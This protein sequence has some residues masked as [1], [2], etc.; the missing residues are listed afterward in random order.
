VNGHTPVVVAFLKRAFRAVRIA[1][2]DERIPRPLRWFAALGL[3]PIPGPV[4][5]VI[6]L[7]VAVPL[8]LFYRDPLK[9]AWER[10]AAS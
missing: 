1:A 3:L 6:L 4:D 10:A 7:L 9:E 8:G 5:E 2:T